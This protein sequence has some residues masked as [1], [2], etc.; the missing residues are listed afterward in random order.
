MVENLTNAFQN[1]LSQGA[2]ITIPLAIVV[3]FLTSLTPCVYPII[4]IIISYVGGQSGG[5][6]IKGFLLSIF[7]A[8]GIAV[9]YS[10]LGAIAALSGNFFGD[11]QASFWPNL[12]VGNLCLLFGL[13]MLDIFIFQIPFLSQFQTKRGKG[14]LGAFFFGMISGLVASPC[15]APVLLIILTFVATKQNLPY[16]II[17]LFSFSIGLSL[18]LVL[19]GTFAGILTS[20]PKSGVWMVKIKKAFGYIFIAIA[21]YYFIQAGKF[22][23]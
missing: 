14:L 16:G 9:I 20:L 21:E 8:L 1:S 4:P 22:F 13:S 5:S 6:K 18:I 3:G 23:N 17:V 7:Y 11:F 2:L 15:T 19:A 10:L 12:L